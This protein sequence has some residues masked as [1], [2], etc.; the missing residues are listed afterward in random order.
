MTTTDYVDLISSVAVTIIGIASFASTM[1]IR[2]SC[3]EENAFEMLQSAKINLDNQLASTEKIN[4]VKPAIEDYLTVL[5]YVCSLYDAH[6][7]NR[8]R[9]LILFT[10]DIKN[11]FEQN[12]FNEFIS[13]D[14]TS[15]MCLKKVNKEL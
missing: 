5:N 12:F 1:I 7:I 3:C 4:N 6:K 14:S 13:A 8:K 11:I 10:N 2:R 15:Y 9:F